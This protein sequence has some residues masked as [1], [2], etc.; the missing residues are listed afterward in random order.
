MEDNILGELR[1]EISG[2]I[3]MGDSH[4]VDRIIRQIQA[5]VEQQ[6][7]IGR[8]EELQIISDH[9]TIENDNRLDNKLY[10]WLWEERIAELDRQIQLNQG[11]P[12][13]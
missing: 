1:E 10:W 6:V 12:N 5:L 9:L 7:L 11:E 8:I 2:L 4:D 13:K 3:M